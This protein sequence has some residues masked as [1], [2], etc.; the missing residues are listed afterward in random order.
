MQSI[1]RILKKE[2]GI[3]TVFSI[4][5]IFL[6]VWLYFKFEYD[7]ETAVT[8]SWL[9]FATALTTLIVAVINLRLTRKSLEK[10]LRP[11][12]SVVEVINIVQFPW[13]GF[14]IVLQNTGEVPA[15]K[16]DCAVTIAKKSDNVTILEIE[17]CAPGLAPNALHNIRCYNVR[18]DMYPLVRQ[19]TITIQCVVFYSALGTSYETKQSWDIV[20]GLDSKRTGWVY[21]PVSPSYWR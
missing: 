16:L 3:V 6:T 13:E 9:A 7:W 15:D 11:F 12:I 17:D 19:Q 8:I 2:L 5:V 10:R 18:D 14:N 21:Q 20:A 4:F 1:F